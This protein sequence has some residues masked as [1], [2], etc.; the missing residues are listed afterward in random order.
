MTQTDSLTMLQFIEM[1]LKHGNF[2]KAAKSLYISQPYLTQVIK[3]KEKELGT[4]LIDRQATPLQ[5][6]EAGRIYYHHLNSLLAEQNR[7]NKKLETYIHPEKAIIKVGVLSSL[8]TYLLPLFL[9]EFLKK[10]PQVYVELIEDLPHRNE[11]KILNNQID[12]FI[13]QNPETLPPQLTIYERGP[14]GYYAII[15]ESSKLYQKGQRSVD[16]STISLKELLQ[17][18]LILTLHGSAIRHQI[19]YLI[20]KFAIQPE[21]VLESNNIFTIGALAQANLGVTLLPESVQVHETGDKYNVVKLP[22]QDVSLNYFIAHYNNRTLSKV[23]NDFIECFITNLQ[24]SLDQK[25]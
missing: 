7:F 3:R 1:L 22:L 9:P 13:G 16:A 19:D 4:E 23:E 17:E 2:T 21:I 14:H 11:K 25:S 24:E 18:K 5:L 6:T 10:Y 15:P 8:G 20:Q 12:F